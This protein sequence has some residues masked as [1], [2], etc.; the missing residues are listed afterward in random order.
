MGRPDTPYSNKVSKLEHHTK[1]FVGDPTSPFAFSNEAAE[2]PVS[3]SLFDFIPVLGRHSFQ[4]HN[5]DP[6]RK[7]VLGEL[8][9]KE[10]YGRVNLDKVP[11]KFC[12]KQ[13]D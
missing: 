10:L 12:K 7:N 11:F 8:K 5:D 2:T 13:Q 1:K 6:R 3:R 4:V 9:C